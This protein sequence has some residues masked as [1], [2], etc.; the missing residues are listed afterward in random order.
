MHLI[1]QQTEHKP[2]SAEVV[3]LDY[4]VNG[5]H[6]APVIWRESSIPA[7]SRG[8]FLGMVGVNRCQRISNRDIRIINSG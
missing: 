5:F 6:D 7:L 3:S 4:V 8:I 2:A 1:Y